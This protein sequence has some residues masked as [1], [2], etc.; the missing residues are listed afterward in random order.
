MKNY[1]LLSILTILFLLGSIN[2]KAQDFSY[3]QFY[4]SAFIF[5]PAL[6]GHLPSSYR[7]TLMARNQ[8]NNPAGNSIDGGYKNYSFAA[9]GN[10]Y[11]PNLNTLGFGLVIDQEESMGGALKGTHVLASSA[12]HIKIGGSEKYFLSIGFQAGMLNR[13]YKTAN[14]TFASG[15]LG[16]IN[17]VII[18]PSTYNLDARA[19]INWTSYLSDRFKFKM[20]AAYLHLGGISEKLLEGN[21]TSTIPSTVVAHGDANFTMGR[22]KNME[23]QPSFMIMAQGGARQFNLGMSYI[24]SFENVKMFGGVH[25]RVMDAIIGN[26]GFEWNNIRVTYSYDITHSN[27]ST[28]IGIQGGSEI[29]IGYNGQ[30][31]RVRQTE[32]PYERDYF[33]L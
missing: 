1:T 10:F 14:L 13:R 2:A 9:D 15:L 28:Y 27:L 26:V 3:S 4:N 18:T 33:D 23:L 17:E 29:S 22:E 30:V 12:F 31:A 24:Q 25:W 5:N 20:G 16:G 21:S 32:N 6:T 8:W 7:L 19:G 11:N